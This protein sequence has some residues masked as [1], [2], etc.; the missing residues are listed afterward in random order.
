MG[1][2]ALV[3][4][5]RTCLRHGLMTYS[6]TLGRSL[7]QGISTGQ[8]RATGSAQ[9]S[10]GPH[11]CAAGAGP[12]DSPISVLKDAVI[13]ICNIIVHTVQYQKS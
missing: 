6:D 9:L 2:A 10:V 5:I 13:Y 3:I 7:T 8:A 11:A 4:G 12:D 1:E